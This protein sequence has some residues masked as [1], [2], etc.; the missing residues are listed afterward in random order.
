MKIIYITAAMEASDFITF[1]KQWVKSPNPSNQ[2]FHN[3]LI[4]SIAINNKIDVISIRP[5]N[6]KL[7]KTRTFETFY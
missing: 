1:S 5:F 6:K 7:C 2:N 4:R 3:K